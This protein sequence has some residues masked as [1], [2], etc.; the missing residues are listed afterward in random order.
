[1]P[2]NQA[3]WIKPDDYDPLRYELL[4][5]NFEAGDQR[6]PWNPIFMPN[7]KTDTNN[8][9]AFSTEAFTPEQIE[10]RYLYIENKYGWLKP[11]G[12]IKDWRKLIRHW[13]QNDRAKN[14]TAGRGQTSAPPVKPAS[15]WEIE[16]L[17]E[18]KEAEMRSLKERGY[19]SDSH[20]MQWTQKDLH[21]EWKALRDQVKELKK[22]HEEAVLA[23]L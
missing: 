1:M 14:P 22:K 23:K 6:V 4:L 19:N 8:N 9:G 3:E 5:R 18:R 7:R 12:S 17:I 16:K 11:D 15:P 20:M 13:C 10:G 21:A 2:A